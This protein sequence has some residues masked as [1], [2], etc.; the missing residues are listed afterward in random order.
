[1]KIRNEAFRRIV[2][3]RNQDFEAK[4]NTSVKSG[5]LV[6]ASVAGILGS[7]SLFTTTPAYGEVAGQDYVANL[8]GGN[9][10]TELLNQFKDW[11]CDEL[12]DQSLCQKYI[13][14]EGWEDLEIDDIVEWRT[15]NGIEDIVDGDMS[16]FASI[17]VRYIIEQ[18]SASA[19][20][21]LTTL[22]QSD[23]E[24]NRQATSSINLRFDGGAA[25][26][27]SPV[28]WENMDVY[29]DAPEST[30]TPYLAKVIEEGASASI[31]I[32][33][34]IGTVDYNSTVF[35]EYMDVDWDEEDTS[36]TTQFFV[37]KII[38]NAAASFTLNASVGTA[39]YESSVFW[40]YMD[41]DWDEEDTSTSNQFTAKVYERTTSA[42]IA[43]SMTVGTAGWASAIEWQ[44]TDVEWDREFAGS[45][46]QGIIN[47]NTSLTTNTN[48]T[49]IAGWKSESSPWSNLTKNWEAS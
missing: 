12:D 3:G 49:L 45:I 39:D 26:W 40:D 6:V 8:A 38:R 24:F 22:V 33:T 16:L 30:S 13:D 1:M 32:E 18:R 48:H 29:W 15:A 10:G 44:N 28:F 34:G 7:I 47:L 11:A 27:E 35:W 14:A 17:P 20:F 43:L 31:K 9:S 19:S 2:S 46:L 42:S 25:N 21:S 41:V 4:Q 37:P 36:G 23:V 5:K